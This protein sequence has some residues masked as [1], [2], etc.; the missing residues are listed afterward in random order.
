MKNTLKTIETITNMKT[1]KG[2]NSIVPKRGKAP[3]LI[4]VNWE[5]C[6]NFA[7]NYVFL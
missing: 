5:I 4:Y 6:I 3:P 2:I 7:E 1:N